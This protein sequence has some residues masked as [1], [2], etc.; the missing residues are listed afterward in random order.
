MLVPEFLCLHGS[1]LS[2]ANSCASVVFCKVAVYPW[3]IG[4]RGFLKVFDGVSF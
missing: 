3:P 1:E 4:S 2:K